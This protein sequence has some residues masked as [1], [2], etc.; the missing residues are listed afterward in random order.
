[1]KTFKQVVEKPLLIIRKKYIQEAL[2][3]FIADNSDFV[4]VIYVDNNTS[5]YSTEQNNLATRG[6]G[7]F[8]FD[9]RIGYGGDIYLEGNYPLAWGQGYSSG[10]IRVYSKDSVKNMSREEVYEDLLHLIEIFNTGVEY[11]FELLNSKGEEVDSCGGFYDLEAVQQNLP[12]EWA[13]E[14]LSEYVTEE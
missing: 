2:H 6:R 13:I 4:S 12:D 5:M 11:S 8:V 3:H 1:M 7:K 14:D 10:R 9:L